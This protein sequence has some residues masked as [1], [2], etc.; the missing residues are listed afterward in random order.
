MK[1]AID[2]MGSDTGVEAIVEG[3]LN[4][5]KEI[6]VEILLVGEETLLKK[7][8]KGRE[9]R[10]LII[11]AP[12]VIG[13]DETPV[14]AVKKKRKSSVVIANQMV[15]Q[16]QA[17]GVISAGNTGAAM[18]AS[19]FEL[20]R[21]KGVLRPAIVTCFPTEKGEIVILDVGANV[22]SR[23]SNLLQFG[24]MGKV[25]AEEILGYR[26]PEVGLLSI[27]TEPGKGNELTTS[28]YSLFLKSDLN[29]KGNLEGRDILKGEIKV[30]VCDGFI[31]NIILKFGE[32]F[33]ESCLSIVKGEFLK[34]QNISR[35]ALT[36]IFYK[37]EKKLEH[38]E[39]GGAVLLGVQ[40]VS[41]I[42]HGS[43]TPRAIKNAVRVAVE[44]VSH[45][46]NNHIE[47]ALTTANALLNTG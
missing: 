24:Y 39:Y 2:A 10:I 4:A 33:A 47:Q 43:A 14:E 32:S 5:A 20:G 9:S 7:T 26:N 27:G 37:I 23:P 1:I 16:G 15:K 13:M 18:A 28:A 44:F 22:D 19:L 12:E 25:Y 41:I 36:K 31:G 42:T 11:S 38:A 29:F 21:L 17:D 3:A 40:G 34:S 6:E 46:V 45:N 35:E 30:V 8:L